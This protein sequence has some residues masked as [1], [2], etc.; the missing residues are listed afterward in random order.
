MS[1]SI[2]PNFALV[3]ALVV[4]VSVS[5][6]APAG[7][8]NTVEIGSTIKMRQSFPAF[9][10]KVKSSNDACEQNRLVKLFKKR[11]NG[12]RRLLGKTHTDAAGRPVPLPAEG[13]DR[14]VTFLERRGRPMTALVH[15]PTTLSNADLSEAVLAAVRFVVEQE[16]ARGQ[17]QA[18]ST[19]AAALPSGFVTLLMTDIE[20][21]TA[22]LRKLGDA[23]INVTAL[24]A[25]ASGGRYG[26]ILWVR[27]DNVNR[28]ARA[29]KA[30]KRKR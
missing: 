18:T 7:A 14:G 19:D 12:G 6:V 16:R 10:G 28:A 15:N 20:G 2:S 30:K 22:L 24:D 11:R 8:T 25:I 21:S 23:G 3:A 26:A 4:V 29:L 5:A 9:H 13:G 1:R 27:R 17:I